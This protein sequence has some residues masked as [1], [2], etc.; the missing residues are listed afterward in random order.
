MG[1]LCSCH[2]VPTADRPLC[3]SGQADGQLLY[4]LA[5]RSYLEVWPWRATSS[6]G[7]EATP[8]LKPSSDVQTTI[9]EFHLSATFHETRGVPGTS[10]ESG[11]CGRGCR[12][13][14]A[15]FHHCHMQ[16][17]SIHHCGKRVEHA[18]SVSLGP[19]LSQLNP[20][21]PN[22]RPLLPPHVPSSR[23]AHIANR[24]P[25]SHP[26]RRCASFPSAMPFHPSHRLWLP[27][28]ARPTCPSPLPN[29]VWW[30]LCTW[31]YL[32][33]FPS[34]LLCPPLSLATCMSMPSCLT[35]DEPA[36]C[37]AYIC[38]SH[39]SLCPTIRSVYHSKYIA[40][41]AGATVLLWVGADAVLLLSRGCT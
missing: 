5:H 7:K 3:F 23:P 31:A 8:I 21:P 22:L 17:V 10:A 25:C 16:P 15:A 13:G 33:T 6:A 34:M 24:Y 40:S 30:P 18:W 20:R 38:H 39:V 14:Q 11:A 35:I 9:R 2:V 28:G 27:L 12:G 36:L 19:P 26:M 4:Q 32:C 29:S 1:V 41:A 37:V